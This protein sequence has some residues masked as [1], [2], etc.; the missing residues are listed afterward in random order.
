MLIATTKTATTSD[1]AKGAETMTPTRTHIRE[2]AERMSN[3]TVVRLYWRQGTSELWVEVCELEFDVTI[4]I[5]TEPDRALEA[6]HHPYAYAAARGVLP[7]AAEQVGT[8]G[9]CPDGLGPSSAVAA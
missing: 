3:G 2:L 9:R 5:P 6:F 4:V 1:I 7:R 8:D